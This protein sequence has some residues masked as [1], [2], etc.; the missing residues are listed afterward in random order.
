VLGAEMK[1]AVIGSG[2]TGGHLL[3]LIAQKN[4]IGPFGKNRLVTVDELNN[5]DVG[6]VFIPGEAF[7]D[8]IPTFLQSKTPLV[9]GAT[10]FEWPKDLDQKLKEKNLFWVHATNFSMGIQLFRQIIKTINRF[11]KTLPSF[12]SELLDIHH[13]HKLDAPSG[14]AKSLAS[15]CEFETPIEAKREGDV[16]GFHELTINFPQEVLKISHNATD[17]SLFAQGAINVAQNWIKNPL[18]A[19]LHQLETLMDYLENKNENN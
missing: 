17:R 10:G 1:V 12:S 6:I 11:Q 13:V 7:L 18:G 3:K 8:L 2:K 5:A 4:V 9:I 16:V 19:G 14:T 15:W